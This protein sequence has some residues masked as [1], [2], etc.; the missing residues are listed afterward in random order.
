[1]KKITQDAIRKVSAVIITYNEAVNL[2]RTLSQLY[3]CDEIVIV[4]SF[5]T[6]GTDSIAREH[7]CKIIQRAFKGFGE[8]KS[9]AISQC[10]NEWILCLD[11]DEYLSNALVE[12]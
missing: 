9:F 2:P 4:D 10:K 8:Q 11:A 12:E 3:W 6:D 7:H 5:S 1:M